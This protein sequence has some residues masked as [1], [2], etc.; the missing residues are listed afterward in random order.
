MARERRYSLVIHATRTASPGPGAVCGRHREPNLF[1]TYAAI[2]P[3]HENARAACT[4]GLYVFTQH[5]YKRKQPSVVAATGSFHVEVASNAVRYEPFARYVE[6]HGCM[7]IG[8]GGPILLLLIDA[9]E[10]LG[11]RRYFLPVFLFTAG[12][13]GQ[14]YGSVARSISVADGRAANDDAPRTLA[15]TPLPEE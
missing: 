7:C 2:K 6:G 15:Y 1:P 4:L 14:R 13:E 5:N 9:C 12:R 11:R 10:L 3:N 8:Y